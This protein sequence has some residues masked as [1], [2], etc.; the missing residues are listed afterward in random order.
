MIAD[1]TT[2]KITIL[3]YVIINELSFLRKSDYYR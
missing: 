1:H 3:K 2:E